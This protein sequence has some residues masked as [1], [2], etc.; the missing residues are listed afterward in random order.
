MERSEQ[1]LGTSGWLFRMT[2]CIDLRP[3]VPEIHTRDAARAKLVEH[4]FEWDGLEGD[5]RTWQIEVEDVAGKLQ[6]FF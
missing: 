5:F 1:G 2:R 4:K 6:D 3:I